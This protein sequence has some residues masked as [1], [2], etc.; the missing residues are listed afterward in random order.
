[1][2]ESVS[3][4]FGWRESLKH[5]NSTLSGI[6]VVELGM[7]LHPWLIIS[8][9]CCLVKLT[10]MISRKNANTMLIV[11]PQR[12][13]WERSETQFSAW[14]RPPRDVTAVLAAMIIVS[15]SCNNLQ[16]ILQWKRHTEDD[17]DDDDDDSVVVTQQSN[18]SFVQFYFSPHQGSTYT[19]LFYSMRHYVT[20][21]Q[22]TMSFNGH[23]MSCKTWGKHSNSLVY[24]MLRSAFLLFL[25]FLSWILSLHSWGRFLF[26]TIYSGSK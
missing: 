20:R 14:E 3:P 5:V 18:S 23:S 21:K 22:F 10:R 11:Y 9:L 16:E 17:D 12:E 7:H 1:M 19:C 24:S 15:N 2:R 26:T 13:T 25:S 6:H 4:Q 8:S